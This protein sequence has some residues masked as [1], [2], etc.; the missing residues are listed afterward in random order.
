MIWLLGTYGSIILSFILFML[1]TN[2]LLNLNAQNDDLMMGIGFTEDLMIREKN[3]T[4]SLNRLYKNTLD[5]KLILDKYILS[6][7]NGNVF[8]RGHFVTPLE[9]AK[10]M[11]VKAYNSKREVLRAFQ[12]RYTKEPVMTGTIALPKRTAHVNVFFADWDDKSVQML[13]IKKEKIPRY[14]RIA[15]GET[16][17]LFFAFIPIAYITLKQL[18]GSAFASHMNYKTASLGAV[19]MVVFCLL[20]YI[21]LILCIKKKSRIVR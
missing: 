18:T 2:S 15:I 10:F 19:L 9:T 8:L 20:N 12:V 1:F 6:Y 16:I 5:S 4:G 17:A 21:L 13:G 7:E 11:V 3:I 14:K